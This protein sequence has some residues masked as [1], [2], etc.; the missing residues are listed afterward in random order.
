MSLEAGLADRAHAAGLAAPVVVPLGGADVTGT[1]DRFRDLRPSA[2]VHVA[3]D[4]VLVGPGRG[5]A[6]GL[7]LAIR[8]QRLRSIPERDALE[9]GAA[10]TAAG[11]WPLPT[12]FV[13]DA[14]W[15]LV[16]SAPATGTVLRLDLVTLRVEAHELLPEPS[17]PAH[18][19]NH[20]TPT[21]RMRSR[22]KPTGTTGTR[23]RPAADYALPTGALVNPVCG[24]LGPATFR[25]LIAPTTAAVSGHFVERGLQGVN[26]IGWSGKS[27]TFAASRDLGLLEGLERYAGTRQR[28]G[29]PPVLAS[30]NE[31]VERG[32][33]ALDPRECGEYPEATY[34]HDPVL[35]RFAPTAQIAWVQGHSLRDDRPILVPARS[36]FYGRRTRGDDFVFECSNG[37]ATGSCLEEAVLHGLLELVE[38]DAFLLGWYAGRPVT[39]IDPATLPVPAVRNLLHRAALH[40]YEVRLVDSRVDLPVPVVTAMAIRLDGGPGTLSFAAGAALDP[41]D[42]AAAALAEALTYLPHLRSDAVHQRARIERLAADFDNVVTMRDHALLYAHTGSVAHARRFVEPAR[43]LP[44]TEVYEPTPRTADVREDLDRLG[45]EIIATG[46]DLIVVDQTT[47]EQ[48]RLGLT[49]VRTITPGLLPIDFGWGRQRALTMPRLRTAHQRAGLATG[50]LTDA[51]LHLVPHPFC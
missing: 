20:G 37:C 49:T 47:P 10:Q 51:D 34:R 43:V 8:W 36:T 46:C 25:D 31:L 32:L 42:A 3:A 16:R 6:C 30:L 33:A 18:R 28:N 39:G 29:H 13:A 17:C 5:E 26:D 9:T 11:A 21:V 23:L 35:Q 7:C 1:G 12:A 24:V 44:F 2:G 45:A 48:A 22:P 14:A 41:A 19:A 38:R 27:D 40:G 4:A 50:D 15:A